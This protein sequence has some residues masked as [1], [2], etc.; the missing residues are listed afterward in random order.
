MKI[1]SILH[2]HCLIGI[3]DQLPKLTLAGVFGNTTV[4]ESRFFKPS[5]LEGVAL[6]LK[7]AQRVLLTFFEPKVITRYEA[8]CTIPVCLWNA[9]EGGCKAKHVVA[10]F[11]SIAN[12]HPVQFCVQSTDLANIR[13]FF[14]WIVQSY[15]TGL[16][17]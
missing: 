4:R 16:S 9:L 15:F 17:F 11:A 12:Q 3:F 2:F 8:F 6:L 13:R 14:V 7:A 1:G 10:K 5:L